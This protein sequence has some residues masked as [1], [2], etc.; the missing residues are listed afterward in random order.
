[1]LSLLRGE[2]PIAPRAVQPP[3]S[4]T[5][6]VPDEDLEAVYIGED[7][8]LAELYKL[9]LELD[10]YRVTVVTT[11]AEAIAA[12]RRVPDIVFVDV[13]ATDQSALEAIGNLRLHRRL[14]HVPTVLLWGGVTGP[15]MIDGLRLGASNF[16]VKAI[17]VS[18][19]GRWSDSV[20]EPVV[21][22]QLH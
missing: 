20:G 17:N 14:D 18:M 1:M 2:P 21:S 15:P 12:R 19:G 13:G 4:V 3:I 11:P 16:L 22:R 5:F 10:G 7:E 8:S 9:R 6:D